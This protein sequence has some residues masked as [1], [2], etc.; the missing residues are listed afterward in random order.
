M[1][2]IPN[3]DEDSAF[4]LAEWML[5]E[6]RYEPIEVVMNCLKHP[7]HTGEKNWRLTP[8]TI[9]GWMAIELEKE[10]ERKEREHNKAKSE[11]RQAE[12]GNISEETQ[13]LINSFLKKLAP[14]QS[15][16]FIEKKEYQPLPGSEVK[17]REL[18]LQ[19]IRENVDPYTAKLKPGGMNESEWMKSK[20]YDN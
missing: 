9:R 17:R 11:Y 5:D 15:A 10:A 8:D 4:I 2:Q 3:F 6:Y 12:A 20:G 18:H 14:E 7:P 16:Q 19:W 1:Y 13:K